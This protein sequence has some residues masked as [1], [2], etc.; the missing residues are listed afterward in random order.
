MSAE[1]TAVRVARDYVEAFGRKDFKAIRGL[2]DDKSFRFVGPMMGHTSPDTF[3]EAMKSM[4]AMIGSVK[5]RTIFSNG[6][7]ACAIYDFYGPGSNEPTRTAE[8]FTVKNG[9][10]VHDELFFDASPFKGELS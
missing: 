8:L 10:I 5:V 1:T 3:I 7:D 4:E 9:K 6:I 2:L